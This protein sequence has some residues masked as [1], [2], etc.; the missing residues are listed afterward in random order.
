LAS[1]AC[2]LA[3]SRV[4]STACGPVEVA[5][6]GDG[7]PVL[8]VHGTGSGFDQRMNIACRLVGEGF[9][10]IAVSRFGY[11]RAPLPPDPSSAAQADALAAVLDTLGTHRVAVIGVSAG[12]HPAA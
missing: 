2:H 9:H 11:L 6:V 10:R 7:P 8:V 5:E 1:D 3:G 12:A 4:V